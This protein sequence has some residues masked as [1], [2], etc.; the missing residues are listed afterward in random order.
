MNLAAR[1]SRSLPPPGISTPHMLS[2]GLW[3]NAS[4][5]RGQQQRTHW[6]F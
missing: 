1:V 2:A 3:R 4:E 6:H 5:S